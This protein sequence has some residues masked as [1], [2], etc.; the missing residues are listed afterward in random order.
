[1]P[2]F[3]NYILV[4]SIGDNMRYPGYRGCVSGI[5]YNINNM[6]KIFSKSPVSVD[7]I[8]GNRTFVCLKVMG[9]MLGKVC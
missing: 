4:L 6:M 1:M 9:K 3:K 7:E 2:V 5:R 8:D